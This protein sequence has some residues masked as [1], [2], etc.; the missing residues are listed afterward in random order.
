MAIG[1][2]GIFPTFED[3]QSMRSIIDINTHD[4]LKEIVND[5][6][7]LGTWQYAIFRADG[8]K[9]GDKG[10]LGYRKEEAPYVVMYN[11]LVMVFYPSSPTD[12]QLKI[13]PISINR[14]DLN[15]WTQPEKTVTITR[16]EFWDVRSWIVRSSRDFYDPAR[17]KALLIIRERERIEGSPINEEDKQTLI[18]ASRLSSEPSPNPLQIHKMIR[19]FIAWK[20]R[21]DAKSK[22][23]EY[24]PLDDDELFLNQQDFDWYY[25]DL[26][27]FSRSYGVEI[28]RKFPFYN[29]ARSAITDELKWKKNPSNSS[30]IDEKY[31][32][33]MKWLEDIDP[34]GF[35]SAIMEREPYI[36]PY[37]PGRNDP[38]PCG[39]GKKYKRCCGR[40]T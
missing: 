8:L 38:C 23:E 24:N 4:S 36:A 16:R 25:E 20:R 17:E 14:D 6:T 39:S 40:N 19:I 9:K 18:N 22:G 15:S 11:D 13:G 2:M 10:I 26:S 3:E 34:V 7:D 12:E 29:E 27:D 1:R 21:E 31:F 30:A 33:A 28:A 35:N 32:E 5:T 37:K